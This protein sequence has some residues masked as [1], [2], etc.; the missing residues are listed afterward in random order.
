MIEAVI[1][2]PNEAILFFAKHYVR[3][4]CSEGNVQELVRYMLIP[5]G[6]NEDC[7]VP[8]VYDKAMIGMSEDTLDIEVA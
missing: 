3:L 1:L 2:N 6:T 8:D 4:Y 5:H 7:K